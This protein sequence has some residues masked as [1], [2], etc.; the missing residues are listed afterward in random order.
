MTSGQAG[1]RL[2]V[3]GRPVTV[4][5]SSSLVDALLTLGPAVGGGIGCMGQGVCGSCRALVRRPGSDEVATVLGCT[6]VVEP[7]LQVTFLGDLGPHRL[8]GY[9]LAAPA[10]TWDPASEVL[11]TFPE[12]VD[13]RHCGGC[14][15]ACPIGIA[16]ESAVTRAVEGRPTATAAAF[17]DCVMCDLCT[18]TC[19][20]GITPN[21]L[22]LFARR[23]LN[24]TRLRPADLVLRLHQIEQGTMR[25]DPD[26]PV[27]GDPTASGA[28]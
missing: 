13:C 19:P 8:P 23:L 11:G 1:V 17:D 24:S 18:A 25:I 7:D 9:D 4:A 3:D 28:P 5:P 22:G 10:C 26:A 12:A 6:T 21:H 15:E 27:A 20:E 14:D 16:V 2:Q